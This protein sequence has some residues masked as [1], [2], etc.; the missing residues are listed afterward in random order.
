MSMR[1]PYRRVGVFTRVL[2]MMVVRRRHPKMNMKLSSA[3]ERPLPAA[4]HSLLSPKFSRTCRSEMMTEIAVADS[5]SSN[6]RLVQIVL[7]L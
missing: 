3:F 7:D 4:S 2:M 6:I 5:I 1:N